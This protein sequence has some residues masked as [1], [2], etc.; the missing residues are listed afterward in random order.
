M[1][2]SRHQRGQAM[3]ISL[4]FLTVLLAMSAAV[5]DVGA[6]YRAHRQTQAT[7]DATALAGAQELPDDPSA[8]HSLAL[9][10]AGRN[11][12]GVQ[13]GDI[14][15]S[16]TNFPNDTIQVTAR[17]TVPGFFTKLFGLDSVTARSK[18]KA[19]VGGMESAKWAAPIGVDYTHQDLHCTPSLQCN[20]DFGKAT[21]IDFFKV[22]PGAFRLINIDGS[23]GGTGP[24]TLAEWIR[25]GLDAYM[26]KDN[27]YYSDP[28]MKP[29][30]SHVKDALDERIGIGKEIL[31]PIYTQTRAQGAGFDYYVV[32]WVGYEVTG[33][34][35]RGSNIAKIQGKFTRIIWEGIQSEHGGS[36]DGLGARSVE[37]VE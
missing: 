3:V 7:A 23:H 24:S 8:A 36:D 21:E 1:T 30:S 27:W 17:R 10:Y 33:W 6:W 15:L 2:S 9:D 11:G 34:D 32:A 14:E 18:A 19:R 29:N 26:P 28:G 35:I 4:L 31:I 25:T 5:L 22:G 20:P 37:L 16:G 12:G 13:N